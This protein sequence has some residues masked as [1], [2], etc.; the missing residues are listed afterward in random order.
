MPYIV[1]GVS[2]EQLA[3]FDDLVQEGD[4][5]ER[6]EVFDW[7]M[8]FLKWAVAESRN[9]RKVASVDDRTLE[10]HLLS[11]TFLDTIRLKAS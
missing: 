4:L 3:E 9:H 10:I 8:T 2:E 6:K 5:K 7:A 1:I 11:A